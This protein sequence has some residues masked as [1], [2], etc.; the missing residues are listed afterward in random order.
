MAGSEI[1]QVRA[2]LAGLGQ[3]L[4]LEEMRAAYD[5]VGMQ[6]PARPDLTVRPEAAGNVPAEWTSTPTAAAD[7]VI[8]YLHGGGFSVGSIMSHRHVA[9]ELG[10]AAGAKTLALDYRRAPE[11]PFPAAV[12]DCLAG[13]RFLLDAGFSPARIAIA[14]DSAGGHLVVT[15]LLAA[16]RAGLPQPSCGACFS[17]WMD[18]EATGATM[19]TKAD[20]DP[21]V[22]RDPLLQMAAAYLGAARASGELAAP[23]GA[24]YRGLAPLLIQ[25][26]SAETLLD[27][28]LRLACVAGA[29]EVDVRLEVWPDMVHTWHYFYPMLQEGRRA[30]TV[31]GAY[32]RDRIERSSQHAMAA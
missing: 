30:L 8:L 12:D 21:L 11:H 18:L 24:N 17:P 1:E 20:V 4:P 3:A 26:G 14:G 16:R 23:L 15:T 2:L 13:Y 7:R 5:G 19:K 29:Q 22:Q 9:A 25:V 6:F 28:S 31:A 10:Y 27:D 32:I